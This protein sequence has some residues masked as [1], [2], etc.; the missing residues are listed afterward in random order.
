MGS[1]NDDIAKIGRR[2]MIAGVGAAGVVATMAACGTAA[3]TTGS[4]T[5]ATTGAPAATT[6]APASKAASGGGGSAIKTSDIPVGSGKI[7]ADQGVVV[8][9]PTA[10]QFKAF[11]TTC[12]HAG[13]P[14]NAVN[15]AIIQCPC[16]G[17][18]FSVADGS[19]KHGPAPSA[20]KAKKATVSGESITIT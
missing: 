14:V 11:S 7:F 15:G 9:Q 13:C 19:V 18:Q 17:S 12:T 8:T 20:L 10:G 3:S 16:H 1:T 5:T 2:T 6:G 4:D